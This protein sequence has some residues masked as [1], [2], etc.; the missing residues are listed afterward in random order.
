MTRLGYAIGDFVTAGTGG[1]VGGF[2]GG[3]QTAVVRGAGWRLA[4][5]KVAVIFCFL[6]LLATLVRVQILQSGYFSALAYGNRVRKVAIHA[7]RGVIFD[8]NGTA[9]LANVPVYRLKKCSL[10]GGECESQVVGKTEAITLLGE[11]LPPGQTLEVASA[12][13]YLFGG[14]T[15]HL[16]GYVS[17]VSKEEL[18]GNAGYILGDVTG[19]G[20]V[21]QEYDGLLRGK[22]GEEL[23]EVNASGVVVRTLDTVEPTPG[24]DLRLTIDL[25][26]QQTAYNLI[27]KDKAAVVVSDPNNGQILALAS[28]PS[29]R[30]KIS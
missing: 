23:V 16:L 3:G 2:G 9:L 15:A 21:E 4:A 29:P 14:Q 5:V 10:A 6:V 25:G 12:R 13:N 17:Q 1:L 24:T 8:R 18:A 26:L 7:P 22:N 11:G 28:S 19:R 20:G 27:A 30:S